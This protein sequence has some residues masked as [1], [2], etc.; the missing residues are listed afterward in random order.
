MATWK[1]LFVTFLAIFCFAITDSNAQYFQ[2][3]VNSVINATL[4]FEKRELLSSISIQYIN[5]SPDTLPFIYFHLWP[6]AYSSGET[7]LAKQLSESTGISNLFNKDKQKGFIDSLSFNVNGDEALIEYQKEDICKL[8]LPDPVLPG[9]TIIITTPFRV[10]IPYGNF[11]RMGYSQGIFQVTQWYPKPAVYDMNGWHPMSYLDQGEFYSEFGSYDVT[12]TLPS[13]LV[14]GASGKLSTESEKL[15]LQNYASAWRTEQFDDNYSEIN[16]TIR[17][18]ADGVHDFAWVAGKQFIIERDSLVLPSSGRT[19]E[20]NLLYTSDQAVIWSNANRYVKRSLLTFSDWIGE[21]PYDVFTAIQ[22]PLGAGAGMEYPGMAIIGHSEDEYS[23]DEVLAHE[24]CHNWFYSAL[25]NNERNY[26]FMDEGLTSAME[27]RYMQKFYPGKKLW[28]LYFHNNKLPKIFGI[29]K[30]PVERSTEIEWLIPARDNIE[31][32]LNLSSEEYT[33]A[34]YSSMIYNKAGQSFNFLR[35]YLG[36]YLFDSIMNQYYIEWQGKHTSPS[37]LEAAFKRT[38]KNLDWFFTDFLQT[39]KRTDYGIK[40]ID[41]G[42]LVVK[43]YGETAPPFKITICDGK[44]VKDYWFEGFYGTEKINIPGEEYNDLMIN[45]DHLMPE[46]DLLNNNIRKSGILKK[47]D[48]FKFRLLFSL[49]DPAER[50]V[51]FAPLVSWVKA[52]GFLYGAVFNSGIMLSR[53]LEYSFMPFYSAKK[54]DLSGKGMIR[55]NLL[56]HDFFLRKLSFTLSASSFGFDNNTNFRV[57]N[58]GTELYFRDQNTPSAISKQL[59][60]DY[61]NV[62]DLLTLRSDSIHSDNSFL[63]ASFRF[64]KQTNINPWSIQL[65]SELGP[66]FHKMTV[67]FNYKISYGG[68]NNGLDLFFL[69]GAMIRENENNRLYSMAPSARNGNQLYL[70]EGDFPDRFDARYGTLWSKQMLLKEGM[71]VSPI[72]D[73]SGYSRWLSSFSAQAG[74]PGV[75]SFIPVKPFINLTFT[76][77]MFYEAGFSAGVPDVLEI[78]VPILVSSNI[79]SIFPEINQRIRFILSLEHLFRIKPVFKDVKIL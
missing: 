58:G 21:Y 69:T 3:E 20:I 71:I 64:R 5:N 65:Y 9:D 26:P 18:K 1:I 22:A 46:I 15:W 40:K 33:S 79:Q 67:N 8:F 44:E 59:K 6:N 45:A 2:Q 16:K 28:E 63:T 43:N 55:L 78:F 52:D 13:D 60:I 66:S 12:I 27:S 74:L 54:H 30:M 72:N 29:H 41:G 32:P 47:Y 75:V 11:S 70:F 51:F 48:P 19:I 31:Q 56:P 37:D 61:Y 57:I 17:F 39:V 38:G 35:S 23:L 7:E 42:D 36:N 50:P 53:K 76:D 4:D 68:R 49:Y 34:N 10:R 77:D 25:G 73:H 24:V 62:S 14:V